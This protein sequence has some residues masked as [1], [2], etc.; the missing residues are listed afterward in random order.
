MWTQLSLGL[1]GACG[2]LYGLWQRSR[3]SSLS[4]TNKQ[5]KDALLNQ[6]NALA[7]SSKRYELVLQQKEGELASLRKVTNALPDP[8]L[9]D[10][11][12][13]L[14]PYPRKD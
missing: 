12:N 7:E 1:V 2:L 14:F 5:L 4:E 8:A 11:L 9:R 3:A 6:V 10:G 13:S